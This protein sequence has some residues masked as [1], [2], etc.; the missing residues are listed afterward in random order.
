MNTK[1]RLVIEALSR[2]QK[3]KDNL[4]ELIKQT[5]NNGLSHALAE[6]ISLQIK[7]EDI[8]HQQLSQALTDFVASL[9]QRT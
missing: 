9:S 8:A 3:E 7:A 2:H 4:E 5:H 6:Q 1:S